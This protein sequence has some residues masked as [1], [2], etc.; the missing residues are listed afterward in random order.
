VYKSCYLRSY[1]LPKGQ[2]LDLGKDWRETTGGRFLE[3]RV[4]GDSQKVSQRK[5]RE[6]NESIKKFV[7]WARCIVEVTMVITGEGTEE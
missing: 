1:D 7:G 6:E 5:F 3:K 2:P 4:L